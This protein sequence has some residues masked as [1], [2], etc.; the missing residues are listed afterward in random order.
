MMMSVFT[1]SL[2]IK[3]GSRAFIEGAVANRSR[4]GCKGGYCTVRFWI[5][6]GCV[7]FSSLSLY[8][9]YEKE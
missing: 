3:D 2:N 7:P 5:L 1:Y 9:T 8:C 4:C 6:G